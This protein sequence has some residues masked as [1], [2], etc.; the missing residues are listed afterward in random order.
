MLE[1]DLI[2]SNIIDSKIAEGI[3]H[4]VLMKLI[5]CGEH[6]GA[7]ATKESFKIRTVEYENNSNDISNDASNT[8]TISLP[9][10]GNSKFRQNEN[11]RSSG[12]LLFCDI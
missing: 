2:V 9:C 8:F 12:C 4:I 5:V 1:F 10:I 6:P 3:T 7:F 11:C